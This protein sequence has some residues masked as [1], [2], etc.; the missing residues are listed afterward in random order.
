MRACTNPSPLRI[1]VSFGTL[2]PRLASLLVHQRAEEPQPPVRLHEVALAEQYRGLL[3][4]RY[5]GGFALTNFAGSPLRARVLWQEQL[6]VAMPA[7][8]PL[9][10]FDAVP[11]EEA[12]RY[13]LIRWQSPACEPVSSIVDALFTSRPGG[14]A[15]CSY[16]LMAMLISSGYGIGVG[17]HS[18]MAWMHTPNILVRPLAGS[19]PAL[20]T[21]LLEPESQRLAA[22]DRLAQRALAF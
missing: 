17:V 5:D 6:A 9:R 15:V 22:L 13:P 10:L 19:E 3:D 8:S 1:A 12:A 16:E 20:S 7:Q 11:P 18:R 4:G 14:V 2:S 21:Y